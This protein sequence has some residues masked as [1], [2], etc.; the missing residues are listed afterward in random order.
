[1]F[2]SSSIQSDA[3][4]GAAPMCNICL[5]EEDPCEVCGAV[6]TEQ[7]SSDTPY[8]MEYLS[9][10]MEVLCNLCKSDLTETPAERRMREHAEFRAVTYRC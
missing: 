3:Q 6:L 10:P 1:M 5:L 8:G 4:E 7:D 9:H 2:S